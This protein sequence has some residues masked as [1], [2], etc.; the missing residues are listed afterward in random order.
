MASGVWHSYLLQHFNTNS[1]SLQ[2]LSLAQ[3][4]TNWLE[5]ARNGDTVRYS[6]HCSGPHCNELCPETIVLGEL[7]PY[8]GG[9]VQYG[10]LGAVLV[11]LVTCIA[12]KAFLS[13]RAKFVSYEQRQF[14]ERNVYGLFDSSES[15]VSCI[16]CDYELIHFHYDCVQ[17]VLQHFNSFEN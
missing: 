5:A 2:Q 3:A 11:V 9:Y 8:W 7:L 14:L 6:D 4:V 10:I 12:V 1:S 13:L 16:H 17:Y 15:A